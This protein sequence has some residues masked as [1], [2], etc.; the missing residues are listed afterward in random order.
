MI[1]MVGVA[2]IDIEHCVCRPIIQSNLVLSK[3]RYP[4]F[5]ILK[6]KKLHGV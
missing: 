3:I 4:R 6:I 5:L 2:G 1:G